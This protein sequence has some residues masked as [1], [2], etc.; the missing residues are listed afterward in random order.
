M[1]KTLSIFLVMVMLLSVSV[2]AFAAESHIGTVQAS[3]GNKI[4]GEMVLTDQQNAEYLAGL[5]EFELQKIAE[6]EA[7][8]SRVV[9]NT[10]A[11]SGSLVTVPNSYTMYQQQTDT[12]CIPATIRTILMYINGTSPTQAVIAD[13]VGTDPTN[14]PDYLNERQSDCYYVYKAKRN[15]DQEEMCSNLYSTISMAEVPASMGISGTTSN[16]WYYAT[17][18][19]S[20]VVFGIYDDYSYIRFG[21]PLGDRVDGCPYFYTKSADLSY[22][23]STRIVW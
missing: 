15:Y 13:E 23:V 4:N 11:R 17:D 18:G 22:D 3:S 8:S 10:M 19:H 16:N 1:K 21:D 5:S 2:T 14:I 9:R 12:Y 7:A 20:L 6:K